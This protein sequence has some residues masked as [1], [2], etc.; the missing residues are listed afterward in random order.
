MF[1]TDHFDGSFEFDI[2]SGVDE[3]GAYAR[4]QGREARHPFSVEQAINDLNEQLYHA[5]SNGDLVPNMGN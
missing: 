2:T 5:V 1:P 3:N 4:G